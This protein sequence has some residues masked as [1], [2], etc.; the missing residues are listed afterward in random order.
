MCPVGVNFIMTLKDDITT[1]LDTFLNSDEFGV[2]IT[3]DAGTIKGVFDNEFIESNQDEISVEDFQPQVI[4]KSSDIP[5]LSHGDTM[6]IES[7]DYNVI[8]IQPDGTGLT[9]VI[10]S[11]D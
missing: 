10:L 9:L 1:D 7:V 6:T 4:V 2:N 8:G 11:K 5:G 3:Y